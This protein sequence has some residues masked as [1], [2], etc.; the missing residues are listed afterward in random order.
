MRSLSVLVLLSLVLPALLADG[1]RGVAG[2]GKYVPGAD[3][4][5]PDEVGKPL[6][7]FDDL[8]LP[9]LPPG[10]W[11]PDGKG[12]ALSTPKQGAYSGKL[13]QLWKY[14][15]DLQPAGW[16]GAAWLAF[17]KWKDSGK[18]IDIFKAIGA[19]KGD[20]IVLRFWAKSTTGSKIRFEFGG[21]EGSSMPFA[22]ASDWLSIPTEWTR[23]EVKLTDHDLSSLKGKVFA[24]VIE[25]NQQTEARKE[26]DLHL[27]KI[28]VT[29][30]QKADK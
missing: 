22:E 16:A 29:R 10:G 20:V 23:F 30:L 5:A 18:G 8:A 12:M 1:S 28:Y 11:M 24:W 25:D 14:R 4:A 7:I 26:Y 17:G 21:G 13:F 6:V 27:D 9:A 19:N 15:P 3:K 2:Q